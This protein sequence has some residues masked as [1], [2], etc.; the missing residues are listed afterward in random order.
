MD[1]FITTTSATSAPR[2]EGSNQQGRYVELSTRKADT[3]SG[4]TKG[5]A[6]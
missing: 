5:P 3:V 1:T 2:C 4:I 6:I